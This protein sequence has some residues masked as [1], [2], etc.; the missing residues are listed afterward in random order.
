MS[1][2]RLEVRSVFHVAGRGTVFEGVV[3]RGVVSVGDRVTVSSPGNQVAVKVSGIED[4]SG[5]ELVTSASAGERIA[6][7]IRGFDIEAIE[8][9]IWRQEH[10]ITPLA[11]DIAGVARIRHWW[12]FWR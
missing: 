7:F 12:Q 5:R 1:E 4:V 3:D 11:V 10:E 6:M 2:F 9:G 8:D